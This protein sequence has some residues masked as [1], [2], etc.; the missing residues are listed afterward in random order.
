M[1]E[2]VQAIDLSNKNLSGV[3]PETLGGC[4]NSISLDLSGNKLSGPI[5]ARPSVS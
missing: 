5:P 3:I 2:A 4:R 1:L